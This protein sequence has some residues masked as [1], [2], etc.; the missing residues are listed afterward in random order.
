MIETEQKLPQ[1]PLVSGGHFQE[2]SSGNWY[3]YTATGEKLKGWQ[4]VDGVTLYFDKKVVKRK[5]GKNH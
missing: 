2:D 3:Y 5:W 1:R 4:N